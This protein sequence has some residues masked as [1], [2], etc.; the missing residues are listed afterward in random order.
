MN[1]SSLQGLHLRSIPACS[2]AGSDL[3]FVQTMENSYISRKIHNFTIAT[4]LLLAIFVFSALVAQGY[5]FAG[6][7][8]RWLGAPLVGTPLFFV[9]A[10]ADLFGALRYHKAQWKIRLS[11]NGELRFG[12]ERVQDYQI[13]VSSVIIKDTSYFPPRTR[14]TNAVYVEF[15]KRMILL[16]TSDSISE[17]RELVSENNIEPCWH[18]NVERLIHGVL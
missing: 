2:A 10:A 7:S 15:A 14:K 4:I 8:R 11:P 3:M 13:H 16:I 18:D 17:L 6:T 1:L 12:E 9:F 5:L